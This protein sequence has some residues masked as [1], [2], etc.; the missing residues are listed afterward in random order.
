V[1]HRV[2]HQTKQRVEL[3]ARKTAGVGKS[4]RNFVLPRQREPFLDS[5]L[6]ELFH[7]SRH[8]PHVSRTPKNDGIRLV[9]LVKICRS[10]LGGSDFSFN[11]F[12]RGGAAV[13]RFRLQFRMPEPAVINDKNIRHSRTLLWHDIYFPPTLMHLSGINSGSDFSLQTISL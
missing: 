6:Y 4:A 1:L 8:V 9:E 3:V 10:F 11:P 7:F 12:D 13:N 2:D 5:D